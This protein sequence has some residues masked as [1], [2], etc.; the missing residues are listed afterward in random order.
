MEKQPQYTPPHSDASSA[1]AGEPQQAPFPAEQLHDL[2]RS[3]SRQSQHKGS[4]GHD[5]DAPL[6]PFDGAEGTPLDPSSP[7]FNARKW[8]EAML[9]LQANDPHNPARTAGFSFRDLSAYGYGSSS[10]YQVTVG[11]APLQAIGIAQKLMGQ[12]GDR[13]DILRDMDGLVRSGEM[14]VVLGPP[15]L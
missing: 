10:D 4:A 7:N 2:A 5:T 9:R 12:K 1:T 13:I 3:Y 11:S 6:T 14:L 8:T 15:G